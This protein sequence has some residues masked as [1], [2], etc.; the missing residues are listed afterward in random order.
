MHACAGYNHHNYGRALLAALMGHWVSTLFTKLFRHE[1]IML[2]FS[3][4][5]MHYVWLKE[6]LSA[7]CEHMYDLLPLTHYGRWAKPPSM[8]RNG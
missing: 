1:L 2:V 7:L 3:I 6:G 4:I 8:T 5:N